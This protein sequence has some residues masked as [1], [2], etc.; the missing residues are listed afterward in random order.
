MSDVFRNFGKNRQSFSL[1]EVQQLVESIGSK[2]IYFDALYEYS[3]RISEEKFVRKDYVSF[4][5]R[6]TDSVIDRFCPDDFAPITVIRNFGIF[7]DASYPWN[8]YLLEN[9][10]AFHSERYKLLHTGYNINTVVG[11]VVRRSAGINDYDE[12]L[13]M[14]IANSVVSLKKEAALSYLVDQG[15]IGRRSYKNIESILI[16]ARAIRNRKEK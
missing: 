8:K 7:P 5:P 12:L 16:N 3:A 13:A 11:A 15:Y 1:E 6:E 4:K 9:Y 2:V 10:L 14:V